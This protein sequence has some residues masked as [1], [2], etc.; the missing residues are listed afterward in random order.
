M[1]SSSFPR[2]LGIIA[3]YFAFAADQ[4]VIPLDS[5]QPAH[6]CSLIVGNSIFVL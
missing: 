5:G 2:I 4:P 6:P 3:K 1:Q